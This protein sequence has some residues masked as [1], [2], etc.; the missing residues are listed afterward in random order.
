MTPNKLVQIVEDDLPITDRTTFNVIKEED[1]SLE[2][3]Y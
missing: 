1:K 2:I 3:E